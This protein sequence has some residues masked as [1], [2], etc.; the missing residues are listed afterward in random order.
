[1]TKILPDNTILLFST[2]VYYHDTFENK[3]IIH[4]T[5]K[6]RRKVTENVKGNFL[7]QEHN[8]LE[9]ESYKLIK[10]R[11]LQGLHQ[12]TRTVLS[13]DESV[14]FYIT[15]SWLNINPPNTY[16]HR[17]N[18][19]NSIVSGV[20]YIDVGEDSEITFC[21]QNT[22]P[23]TSN[24]SYSI[25][26]KEYNL[27]NSSFWTCPVNDNGIIYFPSTTLHEVGTNNS[28]KNRI[29]LGF[30]VFMRGE[31]GDTK[32]LNLLQLG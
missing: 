15:A 19:S 11:I 4:D 25:P 30:N 2:P 10:D 21:T 20:Y 27:A 16:H 22:M 6:E 5:T 26:V 28:D 24:P 23:I 13:I 7:S 12:Y 8:I 14:E 18:H 1:M 32:N 31:L 17:H 9:L 3:C 29:S